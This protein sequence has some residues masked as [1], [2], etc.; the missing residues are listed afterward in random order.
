[1]KFEMY[2]FMFLYFSII[3]TYIHQL[4]NTKKILICV[5][6]RE[7]NVNNS[8]IFF[9]MWSQVLQCFFVFSMSLEYEDSQV[10]LIIIQV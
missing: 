10:A 3:T 2:F 6:L 1:M 7:S 5:L 4:K 8:Q 9:F